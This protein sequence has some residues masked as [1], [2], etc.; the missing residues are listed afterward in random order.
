MKRPMKRFRKLINVL[1]EIKE[2]PDECDLYMKDEFPWS[3]A[4]PCAVL[5]TRD[6]F[7][8]EDPPFA[9]EKGLRHGLSVQQ[10]QDMVSNAKEQ[11]RQL[12]DEEII[13]AFNYYYDNDAYVDLGRLYEP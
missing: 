7:P 13:R 12:T 9:V 5:S 2:Y 11:K 1:R 4:T 8:E 10:A 3:A 6:L